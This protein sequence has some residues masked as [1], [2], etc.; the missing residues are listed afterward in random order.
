MAKA[1]LA[2]APHARKLRGKASVENAWI[3]GAIEDL[4]QLASEHQMPSIALAL[5]RVMDIAKMEVASERVRANYSRPKH[6]NIGCT[7][8]LQFPP[9]PELDAHIAD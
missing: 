7:Q 1:L 2:K 4:Q 6:G 3:I 9:Q 5:D 8:V